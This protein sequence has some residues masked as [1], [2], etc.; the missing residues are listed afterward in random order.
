MS[1]DAIEDLFRV[2]KSALPPDL[3]EDGL[4]RDLAYSIAEIMAIAEAETAR[5]TRAARVGTAVG[6]DLEA[7]ARDRGLRKQENESDDQ[8]RA[9]LQRPPQAITKGAILSAI[10]LVV[11]GAYRA[12]LELATVVAGTDW[13]T[14]L[15]AIDT[16]VDGNLITLQAIAGSATSFSEVGSTVTVTFDEGSDD[17]QSLERL[18]NENSSLIRV[19]AAGSEQDYEPIAGDDEFGPSA[20]S[21]GADPLPCFVVEL[22]MDGAF[23]DSYAFYDT[24][25]AR[26]GAGRGVVIAIIPDEADAK[27]SAEDALRSKVAAGKIWF[28]QEYTT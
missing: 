11:A 23:F 16:G 1:T 25:E 24:A 21:G 20:F 17:V 28:V 15:E 8:L 9:R 10:E 12:T 14:V 22:P 18:I 27:T 13:N 19:R 5:L 7:H 26:F 6:I 4:P 3:T 2:Y